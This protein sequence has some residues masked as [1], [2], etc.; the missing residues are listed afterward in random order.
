[1]FFLSQLLIEDWVWLGDSEVAKLSQSVGD[2]GW[3]L[4]FR[5]ILVHSSITGNE[6]AFAPAAALHDSQ[7]FFS[8]QRTDDAYTDAPHLI[9][10]CVKWRH[11]HRDI[12]IRF[13]HRTLLP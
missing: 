13:R 10:I 8:T 1:M 7:P 12:G 6:R 2:E 5:W 9:Y 4:C 11:F 3:A